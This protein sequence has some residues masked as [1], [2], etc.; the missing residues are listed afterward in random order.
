[1]FW[2]G[3]FQP[4]EEI[5]SQNYRI[6]GKPA[7]EVFPLQYR[8]DVEV[9]TGPLSGTLDGF[10]CLHEEKKGLLRSTTTSV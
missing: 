5:L 4:T 7:D 8:S 3:L 1:M 6:L 10:L 2:Y 9:A